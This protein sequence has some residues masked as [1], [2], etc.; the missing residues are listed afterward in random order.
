MTGRIAAAHSEVGIAVLS[1]GDGPRR[2]IA[3]RPDF[4]SAAWR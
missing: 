3:E 2:P 1:D 4:I